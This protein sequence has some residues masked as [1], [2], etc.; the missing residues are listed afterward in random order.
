MARSTGWWGRPG[1]MTGNCATKTHVVEDGKPI[2]GSRIA[3]DREFQWCSH[4]IRWD[5]IECERCKGI[6]C[7]EQQKN[8]DRRCQ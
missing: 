3:N 6:V 7:R 1:D 2:C 5:Y 8:H 4:G